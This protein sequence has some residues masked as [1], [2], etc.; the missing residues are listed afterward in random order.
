MHS[1][2]SFLASVNQAIVARKSVVFVSRSQTVE[3]I[4]LFLEEKGYFSSVT[5]L[6]K[7]IRIT[8][9]YS[10]NRSPFHRLILISK[11]SKRIYVN[12]RVKLAGSFL[13]T[14]SNSGFILRQGKDAVGGKV[15]FQII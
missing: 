5:L 8:F 4:S 7:A 12:S 10:M 2:S 3:K 6:P 14:N 9:R 15:L 11:S 13:L 1:L